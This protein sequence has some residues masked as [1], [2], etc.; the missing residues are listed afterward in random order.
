MCY[1][2]EWNL[3]RAALL[4]TLVAPDAC[5][6]DN[7]LRDRRLVGGGPL[8]IA[9]PD[10]GFAVCGTS[11]GGHRLVRVRGE[12]DVASRDLVCRACLEGIDVIVVVDLTEL[13]FIDCSGWGALMAARG[14]LTDL[15][16]WLTIRNEAGQPARFLGVLALLEAG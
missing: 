3:L 11:V 9:D 15:G 13:T 12:L 6:G 1:E 7:V 4:Q 14:I 10:A 8:M 5:R 16:G 2:Q